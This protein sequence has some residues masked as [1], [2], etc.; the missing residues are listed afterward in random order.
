MPVSGSQ[1]QAPRPGG[2]SAGFTP[3]GWQE[4][5]GIIEPL[6]EV[7]SGTTLAFNKPHEQPFG[8]GCFSK[9]LKAET[10]YDIADLSRNL[11]G[12]NA[13]NSF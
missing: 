11:S 10:P 9:G 7:N 2:H 12:L 6:L 1:R 3:G 13:F 8:S 5:P 4:H